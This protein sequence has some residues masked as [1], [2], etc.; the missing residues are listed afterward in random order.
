MTK[1]YDLSGSHGDKNVS[2][3]SSAALEPEAGPVATIK[4]TDLS[5]K[6]NGHSPDSQKLGDVGGKREAESGQD[7]KKSDDEDVKK[8]PATFGELFSFANCFDLFLI[9]IGVIAA[10]AHGSSWPLLFLIFGDVTNDFV[11][12]GKN[13]TNTSAAEMAD[14]FEYNMTQYAI[15][16]VY[17]GIGVAVTTYAHV[18]FFQLTGERQTFRLRQKFFKS[19]LREEIAWYDK[20]QSG[21]LTTRLADD[22]ERVREGIGDK[23][24]LSIQFLAQ[25]LAGFI[26]GFARGWKLTLVI[27]SLTP[28]LAIGAAVLGKVR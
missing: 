28:L 12:Y 3:S 26:L 25:F 14:Q 8:R 5:E 4:T 27:M 15:T 11:G 16:Y 7:G 6:T 17:I 21:E 2:F 9:A 20:Q 18:A 24:G 23:V 13:N 1:S 10:C 19:L 22:L